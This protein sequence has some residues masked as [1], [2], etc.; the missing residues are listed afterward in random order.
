MRAESQNPCVFVVGCQRSGTT[1]LQQMLDAHPDLAVTCDTEFIPRVPAAGA[2]PDARLEPEIV[3]RAIGYRTRSG[4]AGFDNLGLSEDTARRLG[5][6]AQTYADF[7]ALLFDEVAASRN[8]AKA[9]DKTPDYC[10]YIP[11]LHG[12][13]P[14]ARF[15]DIVRDGRDVALSM[16]RWAKT[17]PR[18][19]VRSPIWQESPVAACA[20]W[21]TDMV[22]IAAKGGARLG[23]GGYLRVRYEE[24]IARPEAVL[25][26]VTDFLGLPFAAEMLRYYEGKEQV[27]RPGETSNLPPTAGL[28][29]WRTQMERRDLEVFE[30]LAGEL[31]AELGYERGIATI[32]PELQAQ[33]EQWRRR[34]EKKYG[35]AATPAPGHGASGE[36][37]NPYVFVVGC[38]RSGTTL[39]QR[40]LDRHPDLAVTL[41][42]E[43]IPRLLSQ[44]GAETDVKLEPELVE[45]A[46]RY[47]SGSG[48]AGFQ[49]LELPED[50][51]RGLAGK[52]ST[53]AEFVGLVFDEVAARRG[54]SKAG[55]KTPDYARRIPLLHGLFPWA[56]FV[57]IVRDGRDVALSLRPWATKVRPRGPARTDV[58]RE[59]PVAACAL[60]WAGMVTTAERDGARLAPHQYL[61][62]RYEDLVGEPEVALAQVTA[63]LGLGF[64]PE[65][66]DLR[67]TA[68]RRDWRAQMERR[69]V[70]IFEVLAGDLLERLGY[71]RTVSTFAP[72]L[73]AR[74][75][76]WRSRWPKQYGP[77]GD[78]LPSRYERA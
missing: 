51:V 55:D 13:F 22:T 6:A 4:R 68:G 45:Q 8:K 5:T 62:I 3:E 10:R 28:R 25:K 74:A 27:R 21:W 41:D 50:T 72:E 42:G 58:W 48:R 30:S 33:A 65:M 77:A 19:P 7:V 32:P 43:F 47:R 2:A 14:W 31:L 17:S 49:K 67:V 46:I 69:D 70:E 36:S 20:L 26:Q 73:Q 52:A 29:D 9:G 63:F 23:A 37:R 12:L 34:W 39:L 71:H 44:A 18:G 75:R 53:Y 35:P 15:V 76:E 16:L 38:Q 54:K 56:R 11:L 61:T 24:L 1:L 40:M 59:E 64:A 60:W 78:D 57:H 66:L